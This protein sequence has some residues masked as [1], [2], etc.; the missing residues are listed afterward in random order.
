MFICD[1]YK[2]CEQSQP[3]VTPWKRRKGRKRNSTNN[4][5][6][7]QIN[8]NNTDGTIGVFHD[9]RRSYY[10]RA[11]RAHCRSVVLHCPLVVM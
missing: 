2:H 3:H 6:K 5:A 11:S 7:I 8:N 4:R 10:L 9:V 1:M